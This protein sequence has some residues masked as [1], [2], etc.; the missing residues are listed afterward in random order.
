MPLFFSMFHSLFAV[1]A[2]VHALDYLLLSKELIK[3]FRLR[4]TKIDHAMEALALPTAELGVNYERLEW[5]GT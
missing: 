2:L 5:Y 4:K 3:Q 1:P